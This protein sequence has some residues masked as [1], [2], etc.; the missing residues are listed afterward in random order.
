MVS[1]TTEERGVIVSWQSFSEDPVC[2]H[3]TDLSFWGTNKLR[4]YLGNS[5]DKYNMDPGGMK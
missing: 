5:A 1:Y 2:D 4:G 3:E